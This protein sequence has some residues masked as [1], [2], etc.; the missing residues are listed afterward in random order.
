VADV[1]VVLLD[2]PGNPRIHRRRLEGFD[3]PRLDDKLPDVPSFRPHDAN[4]GGLA[5]RATAGPGA[6]TACGRLSPFRAT[7]PGDDEEGHGDECQALLEDGP[8]DGRTPRL[9][10][11]DWHVA[12]PR[13]VIGAGVAARRRHG[14]RPRASGRSGYSARSPG[15]RGQARETGS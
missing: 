7:A 11:W 5:L 15:R 8:T 6:V 2:V 3:R 13:A 14:R 4:T 9:K 12:W 10:R 1:E